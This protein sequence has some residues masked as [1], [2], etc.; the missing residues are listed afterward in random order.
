MSPALG[1]YRDDGPL[2]LAIGR[3][4]RGPEAAVALL[5]AVVLGL[6]LGLAGD[7]T[8]GGVL[9]GGVAVAVVIVAAGACRPHTSAFAWLVPPV[10]R[11]LEYAAL[12]RLTALSDPDA[13]PVCFA[14]LGVL[15]FHHYD[16]V[17]RLRQQGSA[18]PSWTRTAGGGWDGRLLVASVLAALD[19]LGPGMLVGAVALACLWVGES[20]ASWAGY[21]RALRPAVIDDEEAEDE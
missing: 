12:I 2:A 6:I 15:A 1:T 20:V 5:G 8:P 10:M 19:V 3:L 18:P 13:M 4:L 17:Y 21:A 11:A 16:I 9:V 7:G 14:L